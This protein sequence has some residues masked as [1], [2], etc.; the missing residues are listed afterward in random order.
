MQFKKQER[1]RRYY[2]PLTTSA[3][4]RV[5]TPDSGIGQVYDPNTDNYNPDR[6]ITPLV[7]APNI[8]A[9]ASDDSWKQLDVAQMLGQKKWFA[10]GVDIATI[11]SWAGKYEIDSENGAITIYRNTEI[12]ETIE[13]HYE[14]L[15][16]D[17]RLNINVPIKTKPIVLTTL[18]MSDDTYSIS[19]STEESFTYNPFLDKLL[20]YDYKVANGIPA[21]NRNDAIDENAYERI[22]EML[23]TKGGQEVTEGYSLKL[24]KVTNN[25]TLEEIANSTD[26]FHLDLE[27]NKIVL[28]M[29]ML[30]EGTYMII[31]DDDD[32]EREVARKQFSVSRVS[33]TYN[34]DFFSNASI[35]QGDRFHRN[36]VLVHYNGNIVEYPAPI[37]RFLW[38]T[39]TQSEGI[40]DWNEGDH[41][42]IDILRAGVGFNHTNDTMDVSVGSEM[43]G[44]F[45]RATDENGDVFTDENGDVFIVN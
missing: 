41:T 34:F 1:I 44:V 25:M 33:P 26:F 43:K 20:I 19:F 5:M 29:R 27:E 15:L 32:L 45:E 8:R 22:I 17:E 6:E 23:V 24:M 18:D 37:L 12:Q 31:V 16:P 3:T 13:L 39:E 10:N 35:A 36:K 9:W 30:Q 14:A 28:D 21:G 4:L 42:L 40:K 11:P 7:I 38:Q 2:A